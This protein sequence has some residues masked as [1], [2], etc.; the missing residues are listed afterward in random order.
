[1][2]VATVAVVVT[3]QVK[4]AVAVGLTVALAKTIKSPFVLVAR[5]PP[6]AGRTS[7]MAETQR[8]GVGV[9]PSPLDGQCPVVAP[10]FRPPRMEAVGSSSGTRPGGQPTSP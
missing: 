7:T 1:V 3:V 9:H 5:P 6:G 8:G 10:P 2:L 4:S